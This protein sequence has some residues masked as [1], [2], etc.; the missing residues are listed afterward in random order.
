MFYFLSWQEK[1]DDPEEYPKDQEVK[2][3]IVTNGC[4]HSQ[5]ENHIED[6]PKVNLRNSESAE[7]PSQDS[8]TVNPVYELSLC[9]EI[10]GLFCSKA[11]STSLAESE[12]KSEEA[13]ENLQNHKK[14]EEAEEN[15]QHHNKCEQAKENLQNLQNSVGDKETHQ[16][17]AVSVQTSISVSCGGEVNLSTREQDCDR[18]SVSQN[19]ETDCGST[20]TQDVETVV[21]HCAS[22]TAEE[23][24]G[25][26]TEENTNPHSQSQ[27]T[28]DPN[29]SEVASQEEED[30]PNLTQACQ[31][32]NAMATQAA[33]PSGEVTLPQTKPAVNDSAS[34]PPGDASPALGK[35]S[36]S[37]G[38]PA[39]DR[40]SP[41]ESSEPREEAD[42][43][44]AGSAKATGSSRA[45]PN[46][47]AGASGVRAD[48]DGKGATVKTKKKE[49][50]SIGGWVGWSDP[51][52]GRGAGGK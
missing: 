15:L 27:Q 51:E 25:K 36:E 45:A 38:S 10:K 6:Q 40:L 30:Q 28:V 35:V 34:T 18:R 7:E 37:G 4:V 9:P 41:S 23:P 46:G 49:D 12:Q 52:G 22:L 33:Q 48:P 16:T 3:S 39:E 13:E 43:T 21:T 17:T 26:T 32:N 8:A 5:P 2:K 42:E 29:S 1:E 20:E 31:D 19:S 14:S 44:L 47:G 24:A 11:T 50:K